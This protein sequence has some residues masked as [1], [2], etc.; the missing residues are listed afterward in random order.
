MKRKENH[1][2]ESERKRKCMIFGLYGKQTEQS[3]LIIDNKKFYTVLLSFSF[4]LL[5]LLMLLPPLWLQRCGGTRLSLF[6]TSF[7]L[8]R[9][10]WTIVGHII[11]FHPSRLSCS[12]CFRKTI[13]ILNSARY[14]LAHFY[15]LLFMDARW[16]SRKLS[17]FLNNCEPNRCVF[18]Y[19]FALALANIIFVLFSFHNFLI[20]ADVR[21]FIKASTVAVVH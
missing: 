20:R 7:P 17:M 19:F 21:E 5:L 2:T 16:C 18:E 4:L 1:R 9:Q 14:L 11:V 8:S 6:S 3:Q 12:R 13:A 10:Q 15:L